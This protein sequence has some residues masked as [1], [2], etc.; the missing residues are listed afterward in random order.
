MA[1]EATDGVADSLLH[2]LAARTRLRE[3]AAGI[4][5]VLRTIHRS[6]GITGRDLARQTR[7]PIPVVTALRREMEKAGLVQPGPHIRLSPQGLALVEGDWGWVS[8]GFLC[9]LCRG[10][11]VVP[12]SGW[13]GVLGQLDAWFAENPTV[14][15]TL[16]QS[17][18]TPETNLRRVL[19]M[20]THGALAGK[21]VLLLG[22][23]DS[24]SLAIGLAGRV[25]N[26]QGGRLARRICVVEADPRII[27]HLRY[28][29]EADHLEIETVEHDLRDPLP[30]ELLGAFDTVV[31]D[32]PYTVPGLELFVSRAVS[33]LAPGGGRPIF[34]SFGHR[35]PQEQ[36]V[37]TAA[38]TEMGLAITEL[39]PDFNEYRGAGILGG[40]S[41]L[42]HLV[43]TPESRPTVQ[44]TY[45]G[46]L[47]TGEIRPTIRVYRCVMCDMRYRVGQAADADATSIEALKAAGCTVCGSSML[48]LESREAAT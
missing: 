14:D 12:G 2:D 27:A 19:Y 17:H 37:L 40:V 29:A 48:E 46:L 28:A 22:D 18:C 6:G 5:A 8:R 16:D 33:A 42:Y 9:P 45:T 44:G 23:D 38:L 30:A 21:S 41:A 36:V 31:T 24:V 15:V 3:G 39:L 35:P 4:E 32:P 26:P 1:D 13:A 20:Q 25:L 10:R 47:Y 7:L 43:S 34:L 11:H